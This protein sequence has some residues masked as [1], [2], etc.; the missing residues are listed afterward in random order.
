VGD[1]GEQ[2]HEDGRGEGGV[3]TNPYDPPPPHLSHESAETR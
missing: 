1:R 3:A 2:D